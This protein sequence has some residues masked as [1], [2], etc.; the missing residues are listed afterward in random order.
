MLLHL[1]LSLVAAAQAAR[2]PA[3]QL[4]E[5]RAKLQASGKPV[6]KAL[7]KALGALQQK[8]SRGAARPGSQPKRLVPTAHPLL[9][10]R[11]EAH[12][13]LTLSDFAAAHAAPAPSREAKAAAAS[14]A[15]ASRLGG[16]DTSTDDADC[17]ANVH[18]TCGSP[19]LL[20]DDVVVAYP[21]DECASCAY[22]AAG[23]LGALDCQTC[24]DGGKII[25]LFSDCTGLCASDDATITYYTALG[26]GDLD[27]SACVAYPECYSTD[28]ISGFSQTGTNSL[29][30]DDDGSSYSYSYGSDDDYDGAYGNSYGGGDGAYGNSGATDDFLAELDSECLETTLAT[31]FICVME[32]ES[33]WGD[34]AMD[35]DDDDDGAGPASCADVAAAFPEVCALDPAC[36]ACAADEVAMNECMFATVADA[37]GCDGTWDCDAVGAVDY[38]VAGELSF[39]GVAYEDAV[40]APEVFV[41]AIAAAAGVDEALVS[42]TIAAARRRRL[43]ASVVVT[44]EIDVEDADEGDDLVDALDAVTTSEMETYVQTAAAAEGESAAFAAVTVDSMSAEVTASSDVQD[45]GARAGLALAAAAAAAAAA[46]LL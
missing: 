7:S 34:D 1:A 19:D 27:T 5:A 31:Y 14:R 4:D 10:E 46:V 39:A 41:S 40:A 42:V 6:P 16:L 44:Y 15:R 38:V 11:L 37:Y 45:G 8:Q 36:D 24:A 30:L 29:F 32:E 43:S 33:C 2:D 3:S 28:D 25:V 23:S 12:G 35:D 9:H 13:K 18:T 22:G 17:A 21:P 26:F 20:D